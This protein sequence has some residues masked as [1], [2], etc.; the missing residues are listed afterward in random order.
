VKPF[1]GP[2]FVEKEMKKTELFD[3]KMDC[4]EFMPEATPESDFIPTKGV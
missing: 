4:T 2:R 1:Y 3:K